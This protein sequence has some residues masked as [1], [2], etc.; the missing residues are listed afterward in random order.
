[1]ANSRC[2]ISLTRRPLDLLF[3]LFF[4]V[5]L[6]LTLSAW[7]PGLL[8]AWPVTAGLWALRPAWGD[9]TPWVQGI[10]FGPFYVTALYAFAW[11]KDWIRMPALIWAAAMATLSSTSMAA[12]PAIGTPSA[13]L[14]VNLLWLLLPALLIWRLWRTEHPFTEMAAPT[15]PQ[16]ARAAG[17]EWVPALRRMGDGRRRRATAAANPKE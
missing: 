4:A 3:L 9:W 15:E 12:D 16:M 14:A 7:S 10:L 5:G 8:S 6:G 2:S 13:L 11:G 1:M 17:G